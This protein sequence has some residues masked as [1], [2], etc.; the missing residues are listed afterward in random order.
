MQ[1]FKVVRRGLVP[2]DRELAPTES[3]AVKTA[4]A[5]A[6]P[7]PGTAALTIV[8]ADETGASEGVAIP[9]GRGE[10]PDDFAGRLQAG[11]GIAGSATRVAG[12]PRERIS[13]R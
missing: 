3:G 6:A 11:D 10:V 4:E 5:M 13:D 12:R 9:G 8:A 7:L 2:G 1:T